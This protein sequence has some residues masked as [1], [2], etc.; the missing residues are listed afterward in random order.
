MQLLGL[1]LSR[2]GRKWSFGR[3]AYGFGFGLALAPEGVY[4]SEMWLL[5]RVYACVCVCVRVRVRVRVCAPMRVTIEMVRG[6]NLTELPPNTLGSRS[7]SRSVGMPYMYGTRNMTHEI[8][9]S[10][11]NSQYTVQNGEKKEIE[12]LIKEQASG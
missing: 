10:V 6:Q 5:V 4:L 7:Q 2:G 9:Y 3:F 1:L 11:T 8:I 12:A